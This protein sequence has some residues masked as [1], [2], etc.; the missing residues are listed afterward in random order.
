MKLVDKIVFEKPISEEDIKRVIESKNCTIVYWWYPAFSYT[1]VEALCKTKEGVKRKM[2]LVSV[3]P[4]KIIE[5]LKIYEITD[6]ESKL[7]EEGKNVE[8]LIVEVS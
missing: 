8:E 6:K 7:I 3:K 1:V 4:V 5:E 2:F